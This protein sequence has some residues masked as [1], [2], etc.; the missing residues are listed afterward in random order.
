V[1]RHHIS[2]AEFERL[3]A[4]PE[5]ARRPI[6]ASFL[7]E[8][9]ELEILLA[10]GVRLCISLQLLPELSGASPAELGDV[11]L[12]P[13]GG[14]IDFPKLDQHISVDG[15]LGDVLPGPLL[16]AAFAS[17]GG[18]ARSEAKA[19]AARQNGK[20]GGRP[21]KLIA[22]TGEQEFEAER[23]AAFDWKANL[24]KV[25]RSPTPTK[26]GRAPEAIRALYKV[27][28]SVAPKGGEK[29]SAAN[30]TSTSG[31]KVR[32]SIADRRAKKKN[33]SRSSSPRA[34]G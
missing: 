22:P 16:S 29:Q 17:C 34:R 19:S 7:A 9:D 20:K 4:E 15:M 1:A 14:A 10:P 5:G 13:A 26:E 12:S 23:A 24:P 6:S 25:R 18:R 31:A 11:R 21:R 8:S 27:G 3:L 33:P 2:K 28:T 30:P 32:K